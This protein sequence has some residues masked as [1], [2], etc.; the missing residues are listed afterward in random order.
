[1]ITIEQAHIFGDG[2]E[3]TIFQQLTARLPNIK[4]L[5]SKSL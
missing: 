2:S 5:V 1:M 3:F 4:F